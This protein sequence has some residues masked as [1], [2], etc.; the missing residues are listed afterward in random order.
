MRKCLKCYYRSKI[1]LSTKR[2][3]CFFLVLAL[4]LG[5]RFL[6]SIRVVCTTDPVWVVDRC[7][8]ASFK[9]VL[10]S[11]RLI[12][13]SWNHSVTDSSSHNRNAWDSSSLQS[14]GQPVLHGWVLVVGFYKCCWEGL[15]PGE[16][17]AVT[18][19]GLGRA[20]S[21]LGMRRCSVWGHK[22]GH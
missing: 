19:E 14:R 7:D 17:R 15:I 21:F 16:N 4:W 9:C 6:W 22:R 11:Q 13:L 1:Y 10:D 3:S 8:A 20:R 18:L 5:R 12:M 2:G